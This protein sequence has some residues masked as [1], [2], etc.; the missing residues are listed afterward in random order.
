MYL[1]VIPERWNYCSSNQG[2]LR[3]GLLRIRTERRADVSEKLH[4][5]SG[6][7]TADDLNRLER[8]IENYQ[9]VQEG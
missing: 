6:T 1:R 8:M 7:S 4:L 5:V 3:V 9:K 2:C